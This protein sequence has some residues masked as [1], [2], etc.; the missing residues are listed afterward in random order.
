MTTTVQL[1]D[2]QGV[3][4]SLQARITL[5]ERQLESERRRQLDGLPDAIRH[6]LK[7]MRR[8]GMIFLYLGDRTLTEVSEQ[9]ANYPAMYAALDQAWSLASAPVPE[10]VKTALRTAANYGAD[11]WPETMVRTR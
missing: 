11:R 10:D 5:L 7:V 6:T 3:I 2:P 8:H 1:D 9:V 4:N